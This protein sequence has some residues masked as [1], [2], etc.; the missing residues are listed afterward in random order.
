MLDSFGRSGFNG[1]LGLDSV[2]SLCRAYDVPVQVF[3]KILVIEKHCYPILR[4]KSKAA[5]PQK[6]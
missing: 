4:D 3:E 6:D 2:L 5:T 1:G